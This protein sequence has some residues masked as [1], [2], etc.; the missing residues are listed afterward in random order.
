MRDSTVALRWQQIQQWGGG[1]FPYSDHAWLHHEVSLVNLSIWDS[2][3]E[4]SGVEH[5]VASWTSPH[6]RR[7]LKHWR[8][9]HDQLRV[10]QIEWYCCCCCCCCIFISFFLNNCKRKRAHFNWHQQTWQ[11]W[12]KT[13]FYCR[14][15]SISKGFWNLSAPLLLSYI[16][17]VQYY[18]FVNNPV[19][20]KNCKNKIFPD[21]SFR[22]NEMK[23]QDKD[24]QECVAYTQP[25]Q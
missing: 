9:K 18:L 20:D 22:K 25:W 24:A 19:T 7:Y 16:A 12:T 5:R 10:S 13:N 23:M 11:L 14:Q 8:C 1:C 4:C 21:I 6:P 15:L 17:A 2:E 3:T